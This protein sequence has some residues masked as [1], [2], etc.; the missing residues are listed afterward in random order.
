[1]PI[2]FC[3]NC[4]NK[5]SFEL[6]A[7]DKCPKCGK[8]LNSA[9]KP[10]A[11]ITPVNYQPA[12]QQYTYTNNNLPQQLEDSDE[13]NLELIDQIK[14]NLVR[15]LNQSDVSVSDI[16]EFRV[17]LDKVIGQDKIDQQSK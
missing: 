11:K 10:N 9:L 1:M 7:P 3:S 14:A 12:S 4:G 16:P 15:T 8:E 6:K 5:I 2:K 13:I 17:S